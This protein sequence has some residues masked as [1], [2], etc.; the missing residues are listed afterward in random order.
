MFLLETQSSKEKNL[1]IVIFIKLKNTTKQGQKRP[2]IRKNARE[3]EIHSKKGKRERYA[4]KGE[5]KEIYT[6]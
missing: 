2:F 3:R 1:F 4:V 6:Q 5:E